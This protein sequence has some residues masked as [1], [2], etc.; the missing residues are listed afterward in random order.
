MEVAAARVHIVPVS[1]CGVHHL[2]TT[3]PSERVFVSPKVKDE[4]RR[5]HDTADEEFVQ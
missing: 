1:D 5:T 3:T 2:A 4:E